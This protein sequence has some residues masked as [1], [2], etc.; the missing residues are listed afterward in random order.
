[1]YLQRR[2]FTEFAHGESAPTIVTI[3]EG[4]RALKIPKMQDFAERIQREGRK[5]RIQFLFA[6]QGVSE[7]LTSPIRNVLIEQTVTKIA[8][9]NRDA[10]GEVL[11]R[12]YME[13]GF[14]SEDVETIAEMDTY[15]V[16][17]RSA[18]GV[19]VVKLNP[20]DFELAVYG[21]ASNEDCVLVDSYVKQYGDTAWLS[22][23]L[24]DAGH[25]EH[26]IAYAES[27]RSYAASV[28]DTLPTTPL[29]V[30]CPTEDMLV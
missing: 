11:R 19:Q 13:I 8:L 5:N 7:I 28:K 24:L 29:S 22:R 18:Y 9:P 23:Y 1:M 2:A 10:K 25:G 3:D 16:L 26:V 21:G 17:I 12:E 20:M 30:P 14:S 15:N 4:A 6:T 27:L